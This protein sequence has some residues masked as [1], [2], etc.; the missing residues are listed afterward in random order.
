MLKCLI[1]CRNYS[2]NRAACTISTCVLYSA[3]CCGCVIADLAGC[4]TAEASDRL[5]KLRLVS[6]IVPDLAGFSPDIVNN[7]VEFM[8]HFDRV[9]FSSGPNLAH[10]STELIN[11]VC[12]SCLVGASLISLV[13]SDSQKMTENSADKTTAEESRDRRPNTFYCSFVWHFCLA[14]IG[15]FCGYFGYSAFRTWSARKEDRISIG[16]GTPTPF[17]FI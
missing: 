13:A 3:A 5:I 12:S 9:S 1:Q 6:N 17:D 10:K 15:G 2:V 11:T 8:C 16:I 7:V 14:V 4:H